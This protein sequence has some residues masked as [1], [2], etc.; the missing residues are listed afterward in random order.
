[1]RSKRTHRQNQ[2]YGLAELDDFT[3][4]LDAVRAAAV[5]MN[6]PVESMTSEYG[7][8]QL[9]IN[10]DYRTDPRRACLDALLLKRIVRTLAPDHGLAATFMA[11]PRADLS[12]NGMHV[13]LSLRDSNGGHPFAGDPAPNE[14]LRHAIGGVLELHDDYL[15][16]CAPHANSYRRFQNYSYAPTRRNWGLNNR[17]VAVRIPTA[18][19]AGTRFEHR[20]ASADANPYLL[21]AAILAGVH[22]G[23]SRKIEPPPAISGDAYAEQAARPPSWEAAIDAFEGSD[24]MAHY[25]G[26]PFVDLLVSVKRDEWRA[27]HQ[28]VPDTDYR[29]YF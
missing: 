18:R 28:A 15:L 10:V 29:W 25:F 16:I 26:R 23:L 17:S 3:P 5:A 6:V 20:L 24:V 2:V 1:L 19:G 7:P 12:G 13:H 14:M 21:V 9:E 22:H 27:Y 8:G 4:F 11:K